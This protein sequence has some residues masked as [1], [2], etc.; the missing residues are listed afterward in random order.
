MY[1]T[2]ISSRSLPTTSTAALGSKRPFRS[3]PSATQSG[4]A[5]G[6]W[7]EGINHLHRTTGTS[8]YRRDGPEKGT[9]VLTGAVVPTRSVP[10]RSAHESRGAYP[11]HRLRSRCVCPLEARSRDKAL[12]H[13]MN[14]PCIN[15]TF[16][17]DQRST[18]KLNMNRTRRC[19]R[20][21]FLHRSL[22]KAHRQKPHRP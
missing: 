10:G 11:S 19:N 2:G 21:L 22:R 17:A 8:Q 16:H 14:K 12:Q 20:T 5:P 4:H 13:G 3:W 15:A 1:A 9:H 18:G 7:R 6:A